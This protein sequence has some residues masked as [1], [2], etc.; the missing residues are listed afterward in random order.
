VKPEILSHGTTLKYTSMSRP[1]KNDPEIVKAVANLLFEKEIRDWFISN[2]DSQ[3]YVEEEREQIIEDLVDALSY[4][5][6]GYYAAQDLDRAGWMPDTQLV[7]ALDGAQTYFHRIYREK[8]EEWVRNNP[9]TFYPIGTKATV[10]KGCS[11]ISGKKVIIVAVKELT[12][13]YTCQLESEYKPNTQ[14]G[15]ILTHEQLTPEL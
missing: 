5:K 3:Q 2:G 15:Y 6:D 7:E 11:S 10:S 8:N 9:I 14:N 13:E 4:G 12:A 1:S